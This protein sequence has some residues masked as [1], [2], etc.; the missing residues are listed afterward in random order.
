V[1]V[2]GSAGQNILVVALQRYVGHTYK[3]FS[4]RNVIVPPPI[5]FDL[6]GR[7]PPW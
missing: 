2:V 5:N 6:L 4:T 3:H 7:L 1:A